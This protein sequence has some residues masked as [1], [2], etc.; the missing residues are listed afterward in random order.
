M[1]I[2]EKILVGLFNMLQI[3]DAVY[4]FIPF[5]LLLIY[6]F[7]KIFHFQT[8][9]QRKKKITNHNFQ[10][11]IIITAHQDTKLIHPLID[12]IEKQSYKKYNVYIVADDC[13][14]SSLN[15]KSERIKLLKPNVPL[16]SKVKSIEFALKYFSTE[17]DIVLILDAD[18]LIHPSFLC[19]INKYFQKGYKVVQAGFNPKNT[20]TNFAKMDAIGD[21]YN[22]FV[23]REVRM[24]IGLSATI[25][26]SGIAVDYNIY[27]EVEFKD[28]LGGF[29]KKLQAYLVQ[30]VKTIAYAPEAILYDEKT[31][32]SDSLEKQRIRWISSYFKYFNESIRIFLSGIYNR[33]FNQ[34][35][36]GFNTLRPP[37]FIILE[38]ALFTTLIDWLFNKALYY[39]WLYLLACFF[40]TFVTIIIIKGKDS[41]LIKMIFLLPVFVFKQTVSLFKLNKAKKDFL[42]TE[43]NNVIYIDQLLDPKNTIKQCQ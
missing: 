42:K 33:N 29:D 31:A 20:A 2:V 25:W 24:M 5:A 6:F 28:Y 32:T 13:D 38:V 30:R 22:F 14:T 3:I 35:Y 9:F 10:F 36:F 21:L 16:N 12:S 40:L 7:Y 19:I 8:V 39:E 43:H 27:K 26:G 37:L 18:N 41:S 1:S 17:D 23:E 15:Y 11:G 4:I 34:I